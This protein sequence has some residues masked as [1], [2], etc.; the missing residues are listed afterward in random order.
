[1]ILGKEEKKQEREWR[2]LK[3]GEYGIEMEKCWELYVIFMYLFNAI[4]FH[5]CV[6]L[7]PSLTIC[8]CGSFLNGAMATVAYETY[9][10]YYH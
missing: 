8:G 7:E 6:S 4:N 9:H 10:C 5:I 1:M 3:N 2:D